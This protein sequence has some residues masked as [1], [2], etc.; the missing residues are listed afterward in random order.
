MD[1]NIEGNTGSLKASPSD[2]IVTDVCGKSSFTSNT[3]VDGVKEDTRRLRSEG[4][5]VILKR[6]LGASHTCEEPNP[7]C[8]EES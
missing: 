2:G 1:D 8:A 4:A 3:S 7:F 5:G 6:S